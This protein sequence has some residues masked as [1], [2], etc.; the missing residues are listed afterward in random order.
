M[1]ST[2]HHN[3]CADVEDDIDR[4]RYKP[5]LVELNRYLKKQPKSQLALVRR[6]GK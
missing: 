4:Q 2:Q 5:A 1:V 3:T 6:P